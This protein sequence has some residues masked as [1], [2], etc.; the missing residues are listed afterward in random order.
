MSNFDYSFY[1]RDV[2]G[3]QDGL[4]TLPPLMA[5]GV[6]INRPAKKRVHKKHRRVVGSA[7]SK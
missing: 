6:I 2:A 5:A 1:L 3:Q 7:D 4:L